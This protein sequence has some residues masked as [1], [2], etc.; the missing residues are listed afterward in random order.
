MKT[1]LKKIEIQCRSTLSQR[2]SMNQMDSIPTTIPQWLWLWVLRWKYSW[3]NLL[4][5]QQTSKKLKSWDF[6][7]NE[8]HYI[9][10]NCRTIEQD[11]CAKK[12]KNHILLAFV[13]YRYPFLSP[14][15]EHVYQHDNLKH[16]KKSKSILINKSVK[17]P[18]MTKEKS[19]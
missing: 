15:V 2:I 12:Y 5:N 10:C 16:H 11:T 1:G 8:V 3:T 19:T 4:N 9:N 7:P 17:Y 13:I 18:D 14:E 6:L